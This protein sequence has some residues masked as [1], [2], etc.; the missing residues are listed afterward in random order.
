MK[1]L[2]RTARI[3]PYLLLLLI[4]VGCGDQYRPIANPIVSPAGQP[5]ATHFAFSVNYN[6]SGNGSNTEID[7]SGDTN[8]QVVTT[9]LGSV[10]QALQGGVFGA[11]FVANRDSDTVSEFSLLATPTV[12]TVGLHAGSRPVGLASTATN[13]VYVVNSGANSVCPNTGSLSLINTST[14]AVS[15]TVCV[16]VNPGPIVQLPNG[17][18]VYV[19]NQGDNSISVF[20]PASQSIVATITPANGL[21]QNPISLVASADGTFLYVVNQGNGTSPSMLDIIYTVTDAIGASVPLG[22]SPTYGSL[23]TRLNRLYVTNTGSNSLTVFDVS[24]VSLGA[25][26]AIPTLATVTVGSAPVSVAALP[27][28]INLYVANSISNDVSVVSSTSL[29]VVGTVP[30]G[31]NPVFI[32]SEP[33][34]TKVYTA[35]A[36]SGTI[37]IIQTSNNTVTISMPAPQQD[38]NCDPKVSTC[39]LQ[40]PQMIITQ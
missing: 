6:P 31:Q 26:P 8:L 24:N 28:G 30:V 7:V 1:F 34:S 4:E 12:L 22:V 20:N 14:L 23:D 13:I 27:N 21:H 18:K 33:T 35:N 29:T 2:R 19:A 39:P 40:R 11:M 16:G 9:G 25:N 5:Q 15:N 38:P 36:G 3:V 17:G 37:S 10:A 32:A